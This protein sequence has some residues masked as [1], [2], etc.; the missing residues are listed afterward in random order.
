MAVGL[1]PLKT[2]IRTTTISVTPPAYLRAGHV[3]FA[4]RATLSNL[5]IFG[6]VIGGGTSPFLLKIPPEP[7]E[8]IG[9]PATQGSAYHKEQLETIPMEWN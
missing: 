4:H 6:K 9:P 3:L 2:N 7:L 5:E 1:A 8:Q